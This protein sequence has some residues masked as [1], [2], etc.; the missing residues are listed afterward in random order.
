M[1]LELARAD[2]AAADVE[3]ASFVAGD[4]HRMDVGLFDLAYARFLLSHVA[5][6]GQ[7][8]AQ[9]FA[10][11][12]PGGTLVVEDVDFSGS[13]CQPRDEFYDRY[14]VLY[15]AAVAAGGGNADLGRRLPALVTAAGCDDVRWNVFQPL[16]ASGPP[17]QIS[18]VTMDKIRPAI[19]RHGLATDGEID[20]VV[21]GMRAFA[22]DPATFVAG[23]RIVQVW[24]T[25]PGA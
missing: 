13:F 14:V 11:L 4:A 21:E 5:E 12:R 1:I 6:P 22:A 25:R 20:T 19:L 15:R 17:K 2:A 23:P 18:L 10:H 9:M 24:G 7:V 3:N 8:L 16:H